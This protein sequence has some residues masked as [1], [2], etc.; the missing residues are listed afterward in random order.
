MSYERSLQ[1]PDDKH[2][3]H[4]RDRSVDRSSARSVDKSSLRK[5]SSSDHSVGSGDSQSVDERSIR[6]HRSG[7]RFHE[8]KSSQEK[9]LKSHASA[10]DVKPRP[11]QDFYLTSKPI[12][13]YRS[14][15]E[16]PLNR[17][18]TQIFITGKSADHHDDKF[19]GKKLK[20]HQSAIDVRPRNTDSKKS[21]EVTAYSNADGSHLNRASTQILDIHEH[22][23]NQ[24]K[25][26]H[27]RSGMD[28]LAR[29]PDS[30]KSSE[31]SFVPN[32]VDKQHRRRKS[33]SDG[34][35]DDGK[36]TLAAHVLRPVLL[37]SKVTGILKTDAV[38]ANT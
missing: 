13:K 6:S 10:A 38:P 22:G 8:H 23:G 34:K 7:D 26:K 1:V 19:I 29:K 2:A 5:H 3:L 28:L 20:P 27:H 30:D 36:H 16:T 4:P 32:D 37:E 14:T 18:A 25:L 21:K 35:L 33:K 24:Q 12:Q 9:K 15:D 11:H 17:A 31:Q